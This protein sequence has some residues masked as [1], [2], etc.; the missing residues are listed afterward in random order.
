MKT[1]QLVLGVAFIAQPAITESSRN[2][3][4]ANDRQIVAALDTEY[5]TAVKKNDA[6]VM[7]R[8]LADDFVLVVGT[9]K[10][11]TKPDLL[12]EARNGRYVY[13]HQEDAEQTVR[14]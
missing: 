13:E 9:G 2:A 5:Q 14:S 8:I 4:A 7:E 1:A 3:P 10:S 11:Y 12:D 6:A